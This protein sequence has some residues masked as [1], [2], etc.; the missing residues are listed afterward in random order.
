M[1]TCTTILS[2]FSHRPIDGLLENHAAYASRWGYKHQTM[3][4]LHVFGDQQ[5]EL[6]KYHAIYATLLAL[7]EG[8]LLLVLDEFSVV[9]GQERLENVAHGHD[10][11]VV[12]QE[13]GASLPT[14]S[15]MILRNTAEVRERLR[16]LI[17]NLSLTVAGDSRALNKSQY[18]HLGEAFDVRPLERRLG[19]G[20]YSSIQTI[21]AGG[22]RIAIDQLTKVVPLVAHAAPC[23][24]RRHGV[25]LPT[26]GY[27]VRYVTVLLEQARAFSE[28]TP[29]D[30]PARWAQARQEAQGGALHLRPKAQIAFVSFYDAHVAGYGNIHEHNLVRYCDRHGYAYHLYREVPDFMPAGVR[31]N[32]TKMHLVERHLAEHELV[33]WIDADILAIN[34][35]LG[36]EN[37]LGDRDFVIGMDHSG[38]PAN[39]GLMG[40]R[41]VAR[42][43]QFVHH[44]CAAIEAVPDKSH[45]YAG[46]GDQASVLDG[47]RQFGLLNGD[48]VVDAISLAP[49]P[50][51][52]S[53]DSRFVHFPSQINAY[54]AETMRLWDRLSYDR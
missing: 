14:S 52:A 46:G 35:R 31:A 8:G 53:H 6:Y 23:W 44:V 28:G 38:W 11:V 40:F 9:Y 13:P 4:S 26:F 34:Q 22:S 39:S 3:D 50:I 29:L 43:L 25:W 30:L 17:Y 27:D 15:G 16:R 51:Y 5:A 18:E 54:R 47:M 45:V 21:W 32:W 24:E 1:S 2:L 48:H 10:F 20:H 41:Q 36:I 42:T 12:S 37:V 19:N 7:A 33:F 49:A